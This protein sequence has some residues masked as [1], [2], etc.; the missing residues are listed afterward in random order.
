MYITLSLGI[1]NEKGPKELVASES[2]IWTFRRDLKR[3]H[4]RVTDFGQETGRTIIYS[5]QPTHKH[6]DR[7]TDRHTDR[8]TMTMISHFL[9]K[10]PMKLLHNSFTSFLL[11]TL[12]I[13]V[14]Y[15]KSKLGVK[16][17]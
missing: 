5:A 17:F 16:C 1:P 12:I 8:Q 4:E 7:Q 13:R 9:R 14:N 15:F 3:V 2:C 10:I 11:L 6:T